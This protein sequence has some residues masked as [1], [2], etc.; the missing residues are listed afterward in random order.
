MDGGERGRLQGEAHTRHTGITA[1]VG[2]EKWESSAKDAAAAAQRASERERARERESEREGGREGA[3]GGVDGEPPTHPHTHT[4]P[5]KHSL[6]HSPTHSLTHSQ[7][8]AATPVDAEGRSG[9]KRGAM[10]GGGRT[11]GLRG[12]HSF[13][14]TFRSWQGYISPEPC[15]PRGGGVATKSHP[16]PC[17]QRVCAPRPAARP[18]SPGIGG[19][20]PDTKKR[21]LFFRPAP[22]RTPLAVFG[23]MLVCGRGCAGAGPS[24][25]MRVRG[26]E[27][28]GPSAQTRVRRPECAS[29]QV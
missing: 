10:P 25:R 28:A 7:T 19:F 4:H 26:A 6:T 21:G 24:A 20:A 2:G 27:C 3:G 16:R 13:R 23:G 18:L 15:A 17:A 29:A 8:A 11:G 5:T 12:G 14:Y 9:R 1:G 22:S